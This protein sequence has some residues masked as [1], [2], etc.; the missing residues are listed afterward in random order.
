MPRWM[1]TALPVFI[2]LGACKMGPEYVRPDTQAEDAWRMAPASAE[3]LANLPWW[4]LLKDQELQKLIR[5]SLVENQDLRVAV[6]SVEQF[7]AQLLISKFDLAPSLG[8]Q[9]GGLTFHNTNNQAL[10]FGEGI[11]IPNAGGTSNGGTDFSYLSGMVGLKWEIDLWGRIRRSIEAAQAQLLSQEENQRAVV[12]GLVG[13]VAEAYF[14][15]R[16][17]DLQTEITKRTLKA[18]DDSVRI[19]RLRFQHG[20]IPKLDLDQFEAE[21]AATAAHLTELE[22]QM[23]QQENHISLLLGRRPM[24][25]PRGLALTEQSLPPNVPPGLPSALLQRRPDIIQA[26]QDLTAATAHIGVAQAQ[27]FPQF[28]LTGSAGGAGF[29]LNSLAAGPFAT[30]GAS[31]TLSGPLLNAT[32][33][34]YQVHAVEAQAKQAV[35]RYQKAVLTAF[36]EVEDSLIAVQKTRERGEAQEQQVKSLQSALGF[37]TQRYQGGR[38]SYLDVLTAQ[39][40]LFNA[41]LALAKTKRAQLVSVVQ[42]YKALGGGWSPAAPAEAEARPVLSTSTPAAV[43]KSVAGP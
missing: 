30:L 1:V 10:T 5:T 4:E 42:L 36:K 2:L 17:L 27:R 9:A 11:S 43:G 20:D 7:R 37:A 38:A 18:W 32:S 14:D 22:E 34:G 26:E 3:S 6:A 39:R 13:S 12:L 31:A 40:N 29:Q 8:Y 16:A 25:I 35:A 33:L 19:S 28:S 21:R 15:L 24:T 23:V 41:E